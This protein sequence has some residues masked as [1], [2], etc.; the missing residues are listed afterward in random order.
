[1]NDTLGA[2]YLFHLQYFLW[3]VFQ[4]WRG[5]AAGAY[6]CYCSTR[7]I[8][9]S[10]IWLSSPTQTWTSLKKHWHEISVCAHDSITTYL[11]VKWVEGIKNLFCVYDVGRSEHPFMNSWRGGSVGQI[12]PLFSR[13]NSLHS[14]V[15][16]NWMQKLKWISQCKA[17]MMNRDTGWTSQILFTQIKLW[18]PVSVD[19]EDLWNISIIIRHRTETI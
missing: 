14:P 8:N 1:M 9:T 15:L 5:A 18:S 12:T 16:K 6:H 4:Q 3:A 19:V 2:W 13:D 10:I 11:V 17:Y 7:K